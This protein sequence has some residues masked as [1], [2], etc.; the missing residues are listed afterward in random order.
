M[1]IRGKC[2]IVSAPSGAGKT[3]I[4]H[5]LLAQGLGLAFSV[6]ATSREKRPYEVDG[7]DYF[8]LTT[9]EFKHRIAAGA[10]LE[11]EEVYTGQYY[12]TLLAEV[13]RIWQEGHYP[14]FD[15]D[16]EGGLNLKQAL[17]DKALALFVAPPSTEVLEQRL[18]SRGTESAEQLKRRIDKAAHELTYAQRFDHV[19]V[20]DDLDRACAEVVRRVQQ[21]LVA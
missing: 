10:F 4:V 20:N 18:R 6:S 14:V 5:H 9:D 21:F 8:F 11:W 3:T 7:K 19:V 15:V 17:G 1:S 2:V 13:E 16:V 12:G